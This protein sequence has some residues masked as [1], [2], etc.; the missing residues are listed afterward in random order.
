ME[1]RRFFVDL[2]KRR[3]VASDATQAPATVPTFFAND[4]EPIE[5]YFLK[6]SGSKDPIYSYVDY[7]AST[8]KLAVGIT[9]P[10]AFQDSWSATTT[11][12][13]PTVSLITN[14]G[15]GVNEVQ[16]ITFPSIP[17]SGTWAIQLPAR[18]VTVSSVTGALFTAATHGFYSGQQVTLSG[19]TVSG[20]TFSN[21]SYYVVRPDT[22][23][24]YIGNKSD[25]SQFISATVSS[26]G[27][28]ATI[29]PITTGDLAYNATAEDIQNRFISQGFT[30]NNGAALQ[31]S[32]SVVD[33]FFITYGGSSSNI[34]FDPLTIVNNTLAAGAG[35]SGDVS[36]YT[37]EIAALID[38]G[39]TSAILEVEISS[40]GQK[41]TI[42]TT[43]NLS[44]DIVQDQNPLQ[45]SRPDAFSMVSPNG[46]V[47]EFAVD[48][49]GLLQSTYSG[50][51][52]GAGVS[53]M[54]VY[55]A[56]GTAYRIS[57][58]NEG[59]LTTAPV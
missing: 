54:L 9:S 56:N 26:G 20:G 10:A 21:S 32:G 15:S 22:N 30:T 52:S 35:V 59:M 1:A 23:N 49:Q 51:T 31:V 25:G 2:D 55:A 17:A 19:F 14:G 12:C 53:G 45:L 3:F 27:G 47:Y 11:A 18:T 48:S 36:F 46:T 33:G 44:A 8:I 42:A 43:C 37:A 13:A 50:T 39:E 40:G 7:S 5:L 34:N 38:A 58:D 29:N 4:V 24:F 57:V 41:Q 16:K 28:T 6:P